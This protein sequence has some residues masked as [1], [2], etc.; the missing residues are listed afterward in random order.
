V[1]NGMFHD[2]ERPKVA[3][4]EHEQMLDEASEENRR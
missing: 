3:L 2:V 1:V 4:L